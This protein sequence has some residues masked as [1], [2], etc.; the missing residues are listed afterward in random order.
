MSRL[1]KLQHLFKLQQRSPCP[2]WFFSFLLLSWLHMLWLTVGFLALAAP[3]L[4]WDSTSAFNLCAWWFYSL[5][6]L[7]P[8]GMLGWLTLLLTHNHHAL[9]VWTVYSGSVLLLLLLNA[10]LLIY[11]LYSFHFNSFVW[12][13]VMTPGGLGS[14]GS[15]STTELSAI[16]LVAQTAAIQGLALFISRKGLLLCWQQVR[17]WRWL[18]VLACCLFLIQ[19][20]VYGLSDL[21]HFGPVLDGSK[22]YPLFQ[23]VRFRAMASRLGVAT[24]PTSG[25]QLELSQAA[26]RYPLNPVSYQP[27]SYQAVAAPPNV[28]VLVAES[29]RWDQLTPEVMPNTWQF[30]LEN[31]RFAQHYSSGNG[32]R[33]ALFGMFYGLYGSYW[34]KFMHARQSPLLMDRFQQL[35]YQLDIRTSAVFTYPEFNKTLFVNVPASAIHEAG[36]ALPPWQRDQQNTDALVTFLQQRDVSRPF[37]SFFFLESTHASYSFPADSALYSD[38][39]ADVDYM[40]LKKSG[41]ADTSTITPLINR[42]HNAAHWIDVQLGRIYAELGKQN[43]LDSTIVIITGDHGEEFMERGAWGHNSSFVEEQTHVPMLVHIPNRAAEVIVTATSHLDISTTLLQALGIDAPTQDYSL[44][45]NLFDPSP[46]SHL[47]LSDWH[48][49]SVQTPDLKYR[50]PYLQQRVDHWAPTDHNDQPLSD[51]QAT[52]FL[53]QAQPLILETMRNFSV[54]TAQSPLLKG[55]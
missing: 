21:K 31:S 5:L 51:E 2:H 17:H 1:F 36:D 40:R 11:E 35:G 54:F 16:L 30:G 43:L 15:S 24:Q 39:Q 8:I 12:N 19:G 42:Y 44:G 32:T 18:S 6:Y 26:L 20:T 49:I 27:A 29:L 48:S 33:E 22:A 13:L 9:R 23:R 28:I 34:E 37:M 3:Q 7:L 46:R 53:V 10:D 14:L 55:N 4:H 50:I 38:Y 25:Q 47:V 41:L 52:A 45:R